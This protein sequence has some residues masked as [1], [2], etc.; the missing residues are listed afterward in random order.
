VAQ[1]NGAII[2]YHLIGLS[3]LWYCIQLFLPPYSTHFA[4]F[5]L[6]ERSNTKKE[7]VMIYVFDALPFLSLPLTEYL[8]AASK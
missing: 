2:L 7:I 8:V 5:V 4:A 3:I 1:E 6:K